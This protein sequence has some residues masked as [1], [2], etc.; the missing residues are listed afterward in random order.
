MRK[1]LSKSEI[2]ELNKQVGALYGC[3]NLFSKKDRVLLVEDAA[4]RL[5]VC[6]EPMLF[7]VNDTPVPTLKFLLKNMVLKTLVVDMGAVRAVSGGAD[8]MRPGIM[9]I[10]ESIKKDDFVAI[11]DAT[12]KKPLCVARALFDGAEMKRETLGRMVKS[13]HHVGDDIWSFAIQ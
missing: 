1:Q 5:I 7:F 9:D 12:H 6:G 13:V 3:A 11:I 8:V 2:D 4:L 10:D